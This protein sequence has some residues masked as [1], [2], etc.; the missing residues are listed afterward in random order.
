MK[1]IKLYILLASLFFMGG[2]EMQAQPV[3]GNGNVVTRDFEVTEF[4][5]ISMILPATVNYTVADDYSCRVTLDENLFEYLDI[6]T[7]GDAL[8][9]GYVAEKVQ[10]INLKP[11]KFVID[12][13]APTIEEINTVGS[14]DFYFV[15][16]FE[17]RELAISTAGS[18]GVYFNETTTI[19]RLEVSIAGSGKLVCKDF[20]ADLVDLSIAGSGKLVCKDFYADLVDLSVAGSGD[21]FIESGTVKKA[22]VSVAGS[23]SVETRCQLEAMD[24]SIAGSGSIKYLGNVKIKGTNVGGRIKRIDKD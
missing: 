6:H 23:G 21:M 20:Y 14:G 16:P 12:I 8:N 17:A 3:K 1:K 15:T 9:L 7:K 22:D 19:H 24:Y 4:D 5:E 2:L 11:T 10:H 18:G 13:S